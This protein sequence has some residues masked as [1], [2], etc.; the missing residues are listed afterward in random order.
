MAL[1]L[2]VDDLVYPAGDLQPAMFPDRTLEN[3]VT[4]WLAEAA[5]KTDSDDAARHWVYHRAYAAVAQRLALTPSSETYDE[6]SRSISDKRI[7]HFQ[8][9]ADEELAKFEELA[10]DII[11]HAFGFFGTVKAGRR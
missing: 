4:V 7:E 6:T 5:T 11:A 2:T 3:N 1:N 10:E 8:K 9:L